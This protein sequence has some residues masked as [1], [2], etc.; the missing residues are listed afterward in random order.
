MTPRFSCK[1]SGGIALLE[2]VDPSTGESKIE[3]AAEIRW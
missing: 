3:G 2:K 1:S